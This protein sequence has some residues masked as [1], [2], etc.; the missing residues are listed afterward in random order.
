[1][2]VADGAGGG[3]GGDGDLQVVGLAMI[4]QGINQALTEMGKL[5]LVADA[6]WTGAGR[7]FDK[8]E[9]DALTIGSDSVGAVFHSFCER[10]QWGVRALIEEGNGFA[11]AVGLSAGTLY[12]TDQTVKDSFKVGLNSLTGNPYA[13][14]Q[15][16]TSQSWDQLAHP[17][18]LDAD[19]SLKSFKDA[20]N[21]SRD[22]FKGMI[23][24]GVT[25]ET[26]P[27]VETM[28]VAL[29]MDQDKYDDLVNLSLGLQQPQQP[30][31][32]QE[33]GR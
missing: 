20:E 10:W 4:S 15:Q 33:G 24:D 16:V 19:Y 31:Q 6:G 32:P 11:V 1:M 8:L 21:V 22:T 25:S 14:E 28:P 27:G 23:R 30:Q 12:Q 7:G 3:Q 13:T 17:A 29:G 2:Q 18:A 26:I 9:M 5:G